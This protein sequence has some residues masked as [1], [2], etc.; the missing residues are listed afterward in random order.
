MVSSRNTS[1]KPDG[2]AATKIH[3]QSSIYPSTSK[4]RNL[5]PG[6]RSTSG[7]PPTRPSFRSEEAPRFL[8]RAF[9]APKEPSK[10]HKTIL[11]EKDHGSPN[12]VRKVSLLP[13]RVLDR[14]QAHLRRLPLLRGQVLR[15]PPT[16][17]RPQVRQI[18]SSECF[19]PPFPIIFIC[20][21]FDMIY[22][23][24]HVDSSLVPLTADRAPSGASRCPP[25]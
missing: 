1:T 23:C 2:A 24:T 6:I 22:V 7:C 3:H 19:P 16:A 17:R 14:G 11:E 4:G 12:D 13:H 15:Q 20:Y 10:N 18:R 8:F 5:H 9:P 21:N 25:T